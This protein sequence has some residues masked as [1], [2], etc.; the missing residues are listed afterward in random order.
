MIKTHSVKFKISVLYVTVLGWILIFYS[1]VVYLSLRHTL[2]KD[3]D[4]E[5]EV[6]AQEIGGLI[7]SYLDVLGVDPNTFFFACHSVL[8]PDDIHFA[9]NRPSGLGTRL[10]KIVDKYDL[11]EDYIQLSD[12]QGRALVHSENFPPFLTPL[13]QKLIKKTSPGPRAISPRA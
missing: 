13:F 2:F 11:R 1:G 4:A 8:R 12:L 9:Q 5:L 3:L 10:L 6:K 7:N